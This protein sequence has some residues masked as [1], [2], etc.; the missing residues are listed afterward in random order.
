MSD[1]TLSEREPTVK[2]S[3]AVT[4]FAVLGLAVRKLASRSNTQ[5]HR[6]NQR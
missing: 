2:K 4:V 3:L 6:I 1:H 5:V